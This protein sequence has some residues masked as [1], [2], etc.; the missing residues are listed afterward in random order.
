MP[1]LCL[2]IIVRKLHTSVNPTAPDEQSISVLPV[3]TCRTLVELTDSWRAANGVGLI[4]GHEGLFGVILHGT[5][6]LIDLLL[7]FDLID[8][9]LFL[10]TIISIIDLLL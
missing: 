9:L 4:D 3:D 5:R 7:T 10:L 8:L 1:R 2:I 6:P